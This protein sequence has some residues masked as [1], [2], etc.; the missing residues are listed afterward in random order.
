[1]EN[2]AVLGQ[3][4]VV[5]QAGGIGTRLVKN[6]NQRKFNQVFLVRNDISGVLGV[7]KQLTKTPKNEH[8]WP[9][10]RQE[11]S[12]S[13]SEKGLPQTLA[14]E[15]NEQEI[16]VIRNFQQGIPL[17]ECWKQVPRKERVNFIKTLIS[18]L[19]P[20][21]DALRQKGIVHCDIKPSNIIVSGTFASLE[22]SLIDFGMAV[23]QNNPVERKTLFALGYSAPE[24]ILNKLNLV[25]HTTDIFALGISIW[26]L[27]AG[28]LP[29]MHAN[30][31]IMTNLQITHPLPENRAVPKEIYSVLQQMCVKHS[32]Q[33]PP[34]HLKDTEVEQHLKAAMENRF[35]TLQDVLTAFEQPKKL[36]FWSKIFSR[37]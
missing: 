19:I 3:W 27:F 11:A 36:T 2:N 23:L 32:F 26:Q 31:G 17:D 15:E 28:Q 35:Q 29:L 18:Q 24:L 16:V 9:L 8:L 4:S 21:F 34:H 5:D 12:I 20:I 14:F 30:P 10:L 6:G 33:R 7:C 37:K 25:N 22:V 13:F 1:M